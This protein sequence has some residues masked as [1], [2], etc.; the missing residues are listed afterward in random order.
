MKKFVWKSL[1]WWRDVRDVGFALF[2]IV[3]LKSSSKFWKSQEFFEKL[4]KIL[5]K[6]RVF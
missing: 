1:F 3:L 5:E 4:F 6:P 2:W